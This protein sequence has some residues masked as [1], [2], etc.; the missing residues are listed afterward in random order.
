MIVDIVLVVLALV[1]AIVGHAG[2]VLP[3]LRGPP[4]SFAGLL[5]LYL[6]GGE[7]SAGL[8]IVSGVLAAI[9]TIVDFVAPAW[10]TKR[11]G[12]S[13]AGVWGSTI[14]LV[15][16]LFFGPVGVIVCPFMGAFIAELLVKTPADKAFKVASYSFMAFMMTTG[17]KSVY[18]IALLGLIIYKSVAM[19]F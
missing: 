11:F 19:F 10:A 1:C 13:K 14:G 8:L 9:I 4:A 7:L 2:S 5:L 3:A 18:C 12:G 16:G 17:L 15:A 6:A